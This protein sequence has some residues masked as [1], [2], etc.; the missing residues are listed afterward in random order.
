MQQGKTTAQHIYEDCTSKIEKCNALLKEEKEKCESIH[1]NLEEKAKEKK[2]IEQ[3][4]VAQY[5]T[6]RETQVKLE[7]EMENLQLEKSVIERENRE[8]RVVAKTLG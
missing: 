8:L 5:I 4:A 7:E 3:K 2:E 6:W 1:K